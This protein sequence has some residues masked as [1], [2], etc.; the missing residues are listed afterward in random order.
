MDQKLWAFVRDALFYAGVLLLVTTVTCWLANWRTL[1]NFSTAFFL[2]GLVALILGTARL[3]RFG[4]VRG[5][6][7]QYGQSVAPDRMMD[8]NRKETAD[9]YND[10]PFLLKMVVTALICFLVSWLVGLAS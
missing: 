2:T 3:M 5:G 7:Y 9:I 4:M 10:T 1:E 8:A 6:M